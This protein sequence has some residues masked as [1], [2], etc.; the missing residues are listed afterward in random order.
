MSDVARQQD[1]SMEE[2]LNSIRR[3]VAEDAKQ[4]G[5]RGESRPAAATDR[6][7]VLDLTEVVTADGSVFSIADFQE[8][9]A[10][11]PA[12][13]KPRAG[14]NA[15]SPR[16][17]AAVKAGEAWAALQGAWTRVFGLETELRQRLRDSAAAANRDGVLDRLAREQE[18][19]T[20][21]LSLVGAVRDGVLSGA[22]LVA[23]L[24]EMVARD[25]GLPSCDL[26]GISAPNADAAAAAADSLDGASAG[27]ER[28]QSARA[29]L[30]SSEQRLAA[31]EKAWSTRRTG[32]TGQTDPLHLLEAE[33]EH[34]L[35]RGAVVAAQREEIV[36]CHALALAVQ[37]LAE[38]T[39]PD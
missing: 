38:H 18:T 4:R 7:A 27:W 23:A 11:V 6:S 1:P 39:L 29:A 36:T 16:D 20:R 8:A 21:R 25:V 2:I 24:G 31:A 35:A 34:L 5:K 30:L 3:I 10:E 13:E 19:L 15:S 12:G 33:H 22:R 17:Q 32:L 28:V 26:A 37:R 14:E 9:R